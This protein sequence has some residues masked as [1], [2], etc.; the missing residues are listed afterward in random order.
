M[1]G[2]NTRCDHFLTY[3]RH[4]GRVPIARSCYRSI[5]LEPPDGQREPPARGKEED[6]FNDAFLLPRSLSK[7]IV[8]I[9][10]EYAVSGRRVTTRVTCERIGA[11]PLSLRLTSSGLNRIKWNLFYRA[12]VA[13][14]ATASDTKRTARRLGPA[15]TEAGV[16][17]KRTGN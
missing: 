4:R 1:R 5:H 7:K 10:I 6:K 3:D 2:L 13:S 16:P 8:A 17:L 9:A 15:E 11:R 14:D 12:P